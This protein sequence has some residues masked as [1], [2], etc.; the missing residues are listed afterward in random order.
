[1]S[2]SFF[3]S[4]RD[5]RQDMAKTK[6][7]T[8]HQRIRGIPMTSKTYQIKRRADI[9]A[10]I[11]RKA[12]T[13][14]DFRLSGRVDH[15]RIQAVEYFRDRKITIKNLA[16]FNKKAFKLFLKNPLYGEIEY[17]PVQKQ[18]VLELL[19]HYHPN[20]HKSAAHRS[21]GYATPERLATLKRSVSNAKG[22]GKHASSIALWKR[23]GSLKGFQVVKAFPG[24]NRLASRFHTQQRGIRKTTRRA[25]R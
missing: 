14:Y 10:K 4:I 18:E 15:A 16:L 1:M 9:P 17:E 22:F 7:Q 6:R 3:F 11:G 24:R 19:Q 5:P 8:A 23:R 25:R 2:S 21:Q 20:W 13:Y 12:S